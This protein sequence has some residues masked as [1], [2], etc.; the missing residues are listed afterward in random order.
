MQLLMANDEIKIIMLILLLILHIKA[1]ESKK[2]ATIIKTFIIIRLQTHIHISKLS[3][4]KLYVCVWW[5]WCITGSSSWILQTQH[6]PQTAIVTCKYILK[7]DEVKEREE[8]CSDG[9]P[10]NLNII[11]S[12]LKTRIVKY[13][14]L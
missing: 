4:S 3:Q 1:N 9:E 11:R 14:S 7:R 13:W 5:W 10:Y 12:W 6:A 8:T 2:K